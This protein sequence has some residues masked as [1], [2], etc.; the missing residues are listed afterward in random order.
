MDGPIIADYKLDHEAQLIFGFQQRADICRELFRK[1]V[2]TSAIPTKTFVSPFGKR[3]A[4][5]IWSRSREVSL[6]IEDQSRLR[7][8]RMSGLGSTFGGC[9]FSSPSCCWT[10]G[11]NSGSKPFSNITC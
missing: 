11:E 3:S 4:T 6:S 10:S 7:R 1:Q 2:S 8:S 9:A 5:S